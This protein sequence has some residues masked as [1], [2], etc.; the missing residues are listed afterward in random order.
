MESHIPASDAA[1]RDLQC[2]LLVNQFHDILPGTCI[3]RAHQESLEQTG[4]LME[5]AAV[6]IQ[7]A[8]AA[9]KEDN[10]VTVINTTS[11]TRN[12]NPLSG[13]C[14]RYAG[15]GAAMPSR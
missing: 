4:A 14:P 6:L 9:A 13:L 12:E 2:T 10:K 15:T 5:K 3:P 7:Q 1:Y 11:F 8:A